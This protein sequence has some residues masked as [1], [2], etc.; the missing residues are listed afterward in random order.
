M[1]WLLLLLNGIV[2]AGLLAL[3]AIID[4]RGVDFA[5]GLFTGCLIYQIAHRVT[6]GRWFEGDGS[7]EVNAAASQRA[8]RR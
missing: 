8:R 6:Y 3:W 1:G 4:Y 2:V 5:L 7:D